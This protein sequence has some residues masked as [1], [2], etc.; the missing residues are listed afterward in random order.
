[1]KTNQAII[2]SYIQKWPR[3]VYYL[4][5][6]KTH[7]ESVREALFQKPG[8]Y[9]LYRTDG[10]PYYIG[11]ARNLWRRI[12]THAINQNAKH[13]NYW[14]HFSAFILS[15]TKY[16]RELESLIIAAFGPSTANSSLRR[17]KRIML[18]K[19]ARKA[20]AKIGN[21]QSVEI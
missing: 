12:R 2:E 17:M 14:D 4:K 8:I 1:M 19:D 13:Y 7:L 10:T 9:I 5:N 3:Q 18:P 11:L 21:I 20:L 16:M 6:G 15:D